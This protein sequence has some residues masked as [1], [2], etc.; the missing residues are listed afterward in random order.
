VLRISVNSAMPE[1]Q[2]DIELADMADQIG[3]SLRRLMAGLRNG[4]F[5]E[6]VTEDDLI[7]GDKGDPLFFRIGQTRALGICG[8]DL[9]SVRKDMST[10]EKMGPSTGGADQS[11]Q[12]EDSGL[13]T[14]RSNSPAPIDAP[15]G[16]APAT[17]TAPA[18][19]E[20]PVERRRN[21]ELTQA[22]RFVGSWAMLFTGVSTATES[23]RTEIFNDP[24]GL[25]T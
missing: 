24:H 6:H 14:G 4:Q 3:V 17:E 2:V 21:R 13:P 15:D 9:P 11:E 7:Y 22:E 10:I 25:R 23:V 19:V 18:G 16:Q 1:P 5:S 8:T 12:P 20:E